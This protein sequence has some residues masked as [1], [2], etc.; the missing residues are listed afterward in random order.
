M[1]L[2]AIQMLRRANV[3][4]F[5][6]KIEESLEDRLSIKGILTLEKRRKNDSPLV[7]GGGLGVANVE[8]FAPFIDAAVY[9]AAEGFGEELV[10]VLR[11]EKTTK[12]RI[13]IMSDLQGV[14][15]PSEY[16]DTGM[17][18]EDYRIQRVG[19][20]P[21]V[22][23]PR[24]HQQDPKGSLLGKPLFL[25]SEDPNKLKEGDNLAYLEIVR[26]CEH[27]CGYCAIGGDKK[28]QCS[29]DPKIARKEIEELV[30]AGADFVRLVFPSSIN[31]DYTLDLF[32]EL[33]GLPFRAGSLRADDLLPESIEL[34]AKTGQMKVSFA[35]ETNEK[36]R[37]G[38]GK[39]LLDT[40]ILDAV[41]WSGFHGIPYIQLDS[42]LGVEGETNE[43]LEQYAMFLDNCQLKLE[44]G[45]VD[46]GH[47]I[48]GEEGRIIVNINQLYNRPGTR[49]MHLPQ[50]GF[51]EATRRYGHLINSSKNERMLWNSELVNNSSMSIWQPVFAKGGRELAEF[52]YN[53]S[54]KDRSN[55]GIS[56]WEQEIR[57]SELDPNTYFIGTSPEKHPSA[58]VRPISAMTRQHTR[59]FEND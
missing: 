14:Y 41:Y 12:D 26:T 27:Q 36:L 15:I 22:I 28:D 10:Q 19:N 46:G 6:E 40:Q 18:G 50:M 7:I 16:K 20:V 25:I 45:R 37:R 21:Q 52:A 55:W 57:K 53:L 39:R 58:H 31:P 44:S 56:E 5:S 29:V 8:P 51:H 42:L 3:P 43:T 47:R 32:T 24:V 59:L 38:E 48:D 54:F 23:M 2:D 35:P 13:K 11:Q 30:A 1:F 33:D 9:G 49:R 4:E 34:I 17:L